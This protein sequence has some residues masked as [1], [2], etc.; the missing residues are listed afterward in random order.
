[1]LSDPPLSSLP[2][3][4]NGGYIHDGAANEG[5]VRAG[6]QAGP[7]P[8]SGASS[9]PR[10]RV[11]AEEIRRRL[12]RL[13]GKTVVLTITDNRCS[14]VRVSPGP[15]GVARVRLHHMFLDAPAEVVRALA[16]YAVRPNRSC[17]ARING[18]VRRNRHLIGGSPRSRAQINITHRGFQFNLKEVYDRLNRRYFGR[19]L[20]VPITWG[21]SNRRWRRHSI[22]FGCYDPTVRI[23][24]INPALDRVWVPRLF[25]DYIVYHE[26]LHAALGIRALA[27]GRRDIHSVRFREEERLFRFHRW[28]LRWERA[29]LWRFLRTA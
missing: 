15:G 11:G 25:L 12:S 13:T 28:A 1:M 4:P 8:Y 22:D 29:N 2:S 19:R 17:R 6:T 14:V 5:G 10:D 24:R 16:Q 23:I 20:K 9:A 26:M 7:A 3:P 21:R 18:F 27:N